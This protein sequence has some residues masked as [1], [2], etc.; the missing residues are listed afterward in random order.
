MELTSC[1]SV[2]SFGSKFPSSTPRHENIS[3]ESFINFYD[4]IKIYSNSIKISKLFILKYFNPPSR[5]VLIETVNPNWT[6][7]AKQIVGEREKGGVRIGG[8]IED[9]RRMNQK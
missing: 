9:D 8:Q 2:C 4:F 3:F 1:S 5:F 6:F 7:G